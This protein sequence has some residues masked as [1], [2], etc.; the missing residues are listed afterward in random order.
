MT[1]ET[2]LAISAQD[3]RSFSKA[4][5]EPQWL[6][7]LRERALANVE[8][9]DM[10]KPDKTNVR[11]WNFFDFPQ[12][13]VEGKVVTS[14][15]ELPAEV[16]A[17]VEETQ[18]TLYI[19]HNN[20]AAYLKVSD[21][22]KAQGV[23]VTDLFTA[24]QEHSDLVQKYFMTEAVEVD[25]HKLTA[26]HTALVNGGLFVYVPKEVKVVEPIQ[27]VFFTDHEDTS[28]FNHV[29]IVADNFS[30]VTYVENYLS[31]GAAK[32]LA[33]IVEEV[34]VNDGAKVTFGAVDTLA[35]GFTT[36]VNRRGET[37]R[38]ASLDWA[39][40]LMNDGDTISEHI[41]HLRGDGSSADAKSVV[42]G[43]GKQ[44]QNFTTEVRNWGKSSDGQILTHAVMK[45]SSRAI[46]N[47]IGKIEHGATKANAEQESRIL[48]LSET[49][50]GDANPILLIEEDDV[51]AGHA[52]SVGRVDQLQLYYLMSRGISRENAERLVIH[53]FLEPVVS[54][55]PIA[56]VRKQLVEVIERKVK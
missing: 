28:L 12:L 14:L 7:E 9:L 55:L 2:K 39:L 46:F 6:T 22:L 43:R 49:A 11:S 50:R 26:L 44:S 51:T 45:D 19:Q 20:T 29:L 32:G 4:H 37:K 47:G 42:V 16:Q 52:A 17:I 15:T 34:I 56:S 1:V 27:A 48:M 8:T 25:E 30:E 13:N 40:G 36:Y 31:I 23:I 53:G 3:V 41:T 38:D 18:Q 10:I 54:K 35:E 5:N 21:E 24:V 33:N